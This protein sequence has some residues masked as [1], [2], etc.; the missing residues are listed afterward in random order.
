MGYDPAEI[1][2]ES[3]FEAASMGF[4]SEKAIWLFG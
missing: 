2:T 1:Y 4:H 3:P